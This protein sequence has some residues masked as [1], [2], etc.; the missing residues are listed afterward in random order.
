M[1]KPSELDSLPDEFPSLE[2]AGQF[3]DTHDT[4]KFL[5][6]FRT[7]HQGRK[8]QAIS[9]YWKNPS[10]L[11]FAGNRDPIAAIAE[12][13]QDV[14][15]KALEEGWNGPPFDPFA[16]A[17]ILKIQVIPLNNMGGD[18]IRDAR[19]FADSSGQLT[20]EYNPNK[21]QAR[22]RFS[23]CHEIA[24]SFFSDCQDSVHHRLAPQQMHGTD[25]QLELLCNLGAAE[26]L[27]PIGSFGDIAKSAITIDKALDLRRKFEVSTEAVLLRTV[28]LS[29]R[30]LAAFSAVANESA[31]TTKYTIEYCVSSRGWDAGLQPGLVLPE[32]TALK[33]CTAIGYTAKGR[34]VWST[35]MGQFTVE[36][37]GVPPYPAPVEARLPDYYLSKLRPNQGI[38]RVVGLIRPE[39]GQEQVYPS[40]MH[41]R[42]DAT[43]PI[44]STHTIIAHV[45]NDKTPNWGAGFGRFI[46][47]KWPEVQQNFRN[48]WMHQGGFRLGEV[49]ST[50][51]NPAISVLHMVAQHGYQ[52]SSKPL[53]RYE[54]LRECLEQLGD[55]AL[56][57]KAR[58]QMPRIGTG[59]AGGSWPVI[60]EMIQDTVCRRGVSVTVCELP[61]VRLRELPQ[62]E[63]I[64]QKRRTA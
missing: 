45:V 19:I 4:S 15:F 12:K 37:V 46:A 38:P 32:H 2:D 33:Q 54:K 52:R 59:E 23:I 7:I 30:P 6:A 8:R 25:R 9:T 62:L 28:K 10:V 42:R 48:L 47:K 21:S 1:T 58:V 35:G 39:S 44:D 27:M 36:A 64:E 14:V 17:E 16:L 5:G 24:H 43:E 61:G 51:V 29:E 13:A 41:L 31:R 34:E 56:G 53:L 3:W 18:A 26:L 60:E 55:V 40:V 20:I 50:E 22:I 49:Q 63:L 11:K 57:K